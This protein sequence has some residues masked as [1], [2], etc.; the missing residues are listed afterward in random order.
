M[1]DVNAAPQE[2]PASSPPAA[3]NGTGR[4]GRPR[5]T[6]RTRGTDV[7]F[8]PLRTRRTWIALRAFAATG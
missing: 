4:A 8:G 6:R 3:A 2:S 7:A 1:T 5:G